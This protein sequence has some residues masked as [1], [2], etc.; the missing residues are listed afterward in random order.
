MFSYEDLP[1]NHELLPFFNHCDDTQRTQLQAGFH[2]GV[3]LILNVRMAKEGSYTCIFADCKATFEEMTH[4]IHHL[5]HCP[6]FCEGGRYY[7]PNCENQHTLRVLG[8]QGQKDR[9][10][11]KDSDALP[12]FLREMEI[13]PSTNSIEA[14][15][16]RGSPVD[17][18]NLGTASKQRALPKKIEAWSQHK[19]EIHHLYI[20]LALPLKDVVT[21]MKKRGFEATE[22]QY[23]LQLRRWR[24]RKNLKCHE[25]DQLLE[26][27]KQ[28]E[29]KLPTEGEDITFHGV[30]VSSQRA[31]RLT[32]SNKATK[33]NTVLNDDQALA[34][35]E[36][37]LPCP[38]NTSLTSSA[39]FGS[40]DTHTNQIESM[41]GSQL[42]SDDFVDFD[43]DF[44]LDLSLN[45]NP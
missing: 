38:I 39:I 16:H 40:L 8:T 5:L 19:T 1:P 37:S 34:S 36:F 26:E 11:P 30:K 29:T 21:E 32:R 42:D 33:L 45:L 6:E 44:D 12:P 10:V 27:A 15:V 2:I 35:T 13:S 17:Q 41:C 3:L 28:K 25:R 14:A 7:C 4:M 23:K 18:G 9:L 22:K 24:F 20:D 31:K 43:F